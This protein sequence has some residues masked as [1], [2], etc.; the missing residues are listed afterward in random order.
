VVGYLRR[1]EQVTNVYCAVFRH[2]TLMP[3]HREVRALCYMVDRHHPQYAGN[4]PLE[5]QARL[6]R[7][8][9]GRSGMNVDYVRSTVA[10]L[11]QCGVTD[12]ALEALVLR[13]G[14]YHRERRGG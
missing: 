14:R 8:G 2:V 9:R 11:R 1:R 5:E 12:R 13:L 7:R 10:H 6:V 4:L 3:C